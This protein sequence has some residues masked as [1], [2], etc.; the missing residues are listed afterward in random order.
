[1]ILV[2]SHGVMKMDVDVDVCGKLMVH[3]LLRHNPVDV[4]V[5]GK[6]FQN[7]SNFWN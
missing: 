2:R 5:C 6:I 1:M 3:E 4:D 7:M